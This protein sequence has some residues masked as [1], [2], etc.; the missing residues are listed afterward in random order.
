MELNLFLIAV[1]RRASPPHPLR[2]H[3]AIIW[4]IGAISR[5]SRPNISGTFAVADI[6]FESIATPFYFSC[7]LFSLCSPFFISIYLSISLSL[8]IYIYIYMCVCVC[9]CVCVCARVNI[10]L[11]F[12]GGRYVNGCLQSCDDGDGCNRAPAPLMTPTTALF[13]SALSAAI[14]R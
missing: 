6:C 8:Y 13:I 11:S 9:V 1:S 14:F 3:L 4:L 5:C 7:F 10:F 12:C 2:L